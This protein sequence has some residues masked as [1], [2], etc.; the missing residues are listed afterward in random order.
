MQDKSTKNL[1]EVG[2]SSEIRYG[3]FIVQVRVVSVLANLLV[4]TVVTLTC[5]VRVINKLVTLFHT[6]ETSL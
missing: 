3:N 6:K 4:K 1:N 5:K 2:V